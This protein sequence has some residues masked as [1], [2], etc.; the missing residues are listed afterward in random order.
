MSLLFQG[1]GTIAG[2][3]DLG[4]VETFPVFQSAQR[5][6]I[7]QDTCYV[8]LEAQLVRGGLLHPDSPQGLSLEESFS[9][10]LINGRIY[11]SLSEIE[12]ALHLVQQSQF[13]KSHP[14]PVAAAMEV[15]YI[16][17]QVGL[18]ILELQAS[19]GGFW[20]DSNEEILSLERAKGLISAAL[21]DKLCARLDRQELID[22]NTAEKL[23]LSDFYQRCILNQE[24]GLRLLPVNQ[25]SRGT[26]CLRSGIN[27]GIFRAVQEGL[28]D[29]QVTVRLLEAQLFAGGITDPRTGHRLTVDEAVRHGLMDQDLSCALLT[30]QLQSGG[31]IDPVSRERLELDESIQKNLLSPRMALKVLESLWAF[32]GIL[33]PESGELL[34]IT[35]AL[36]QGVISGDLARNILHKRHSIGAIYSPESGQVIPLAHVEEVLG[37]EAAMVLQQTVIPDILPA[38]ASKGSLQCSGS[39]IS[40][41][42]SPAPASLLGAQSD[43]SFLEVS[44][45]QEQD[46]H[47]LLSY[48]MTHSYINAHSGERLVLLEPE[49]ME[50]TNVTGT[51]KAQTRHKPQLIEPSDSE[52]GEAPEFIRPLN[53]TKQENIHILI[54][55]KERST[56]S[57]SRDD[58]QGQDVLSVE[59]GIDITDNISKTAFNTDEQRVAGNASKETSTDGTLVNLLVTGSKVTEPEPEASALFV[60][61]VETLSTDSTIQSL[62]SDMEGTRGRVQLLGMTEL[63]SWRK[64]QVPV[65]DQNILEENQV[66]CSLSVKNLLDIKSENTADKTTSQDTVKESQPDQLNGNA[67]QVLQVWNTDVSDVNKQISAQTDTN[68][69]M[70]N[71]DLLKINPSTMSVDISEERELDHMAT[72]LLQG[73]LLNIGNQRLPLDEAV[74]QD[75][76]PYNTAVKVMSK[77]ELLGGFLNVCACQQLSFDD[78]IQE[79]LLDKDFMTKVIKSEKM[80]AGVFDVEHGRVCSLREA[81]EEGLLDTDTVSYLLEGQIV[82]GG[83]IDLKKG[84]KVSVE[85]A[86]KLGLIEE[87]Q[88]DQ[89]LI[90]EKACH[91]KNSDPHVIQT[92][93]KLQLQMNGIIDPETKQPVPLQQA[94]QK[95]LIGHEEAEQMLLEQIAGGGIVHHG[96]G[97]RISVTNAIHQ[98]LIDSSLAPKLEQF[99]KSRQNQFSSDLN[100]PHA[101]AAVRF[102]YDDASKSNIT[103]ADAV[104]CGLIDQGAANKAMDSLFVKSGVLDPKNACLIPYSELIKQGKIDTGKGWRFLE[105]RP[106]RGIP[107]KENGCLMTVPE[108][109]NAG[110][111]DSIPALRLLQ[112]QADSGGIINIKSGEKLPLLE[113]VEKGFVQKDM[114][115]IIAKNQFLKGG[116]VS[117]ISSQRVPSLKEAVQHGLISKEMA[118]ELCDNLGLV[119]PFAPQGIPYQESSTVKSCDNVEVRGVHFADIQEPHSMTTELHKDMNEQ[120]QVIQQ[121]PSSELEDQKHANVSSMAVGKDPDVSLEVLSQFV[122]KAEKRLQEAIEECIPKQ[123][124]AVEPQQESEPRLSVPVSQISAIESV[125]GKSYDVIPQT[126]KPD[127]K[128]QPGPVV[129]GTETDDITKAPEPL[130]HAKSIHESVEK[131]ED[132]NEMDVYSDERSVEPNLEAEK[133]VGIEF[134]IRRTP[135]VHT[136]SDILD[137]DQKEVKVDLYIGESSVVAPR[138]DAKGSH[139]L[140]TSIVKKSEHYSKTPGVTV[141]PLVYDNENTTLRADIEI[142]RES[143]DTDQESKD[144][145]IKEESRVYLADLKPSLNVTSPIER[146]NIMFKRD[147]VINQRSEDI[148][149]KKGVRLESEVVKASD[150]TDTSLLEESENTFSKKADA[151]DQKDA[152]DLKEF[153]EVKDYLEDLKSP[154][155]MVTSSTERK[156]GKEVVNDQNSEDAVM[157]KKVDLEV[158]KGG[159]MTEVSLEVDIEVEAG[160]EIIKIHQKFDDSSGEDTGGQKYVEQIKTDE[161]H[162]LALKS[163]CKYVTSPAEGAK[164]FEK[165]ATDTNQ[166]DANLGNLDITKTQ[167]KSEGSSS[168]HMEKRFT[169]EFIDND[170]DEK[171]FDTD[172]KIVGQVKAEMLGVPNTG[173]S[174]KSI[175]EGLQ[176]KIEVVKSQHVENTSPGAETSKYDA[177][178]LMDGCKNTKDELQRHIKPTVI[179]DAS[180]TPVEPEMDH[181]EDQASDQDKKRKKKRKNKKTKM[182]ITQKESEDSKVDEPVPRPPTDVPPQRETISAVRKDE[183]EPQPQ[184][185]NQA[186]LEKEALLMKAKE[187]ILRK[188]FERG[189]SEK[190]AAEELEALR[191]GSAKERHVTAEDRVK[192]EEKSSSLDVKKTETDVTHQTKQ[193]DKNKNLLPGNVITES[194]STQSPF[195]QTDLTNDSIY[196]KQNLIYAESSDAAMVPNKQISRPTVFDR[197][198]GK[199]QHQKNEKP[200]DSAVH[201]E[202][203]ATVTGENKDQQKSVTSTTFVTDAV[204][205]LVEKMNKEPLQALT[206]EYSYTASE[207]NDESSIEESSESRLSNLEEVPESD[208]T[209]CWE[210][211]DVEEHQEGVDEKQTED[212]VRKQ[213]SPP[214]ISK[215]S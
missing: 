51:I 5:G 112:C 182:V 142:E 207:F 196:K 168:E 56:F 74:M 154:C 114:A 3:I 4:T 214:Q 132:K 34:L 49:L 78:V 184:K 102:M 150:L 204:G 197:Q 107:N 94:L 54:D 77:A 177:A 111:V 59:G 146:M 185:S 10:G 199:T 73:G 128:M 181:P 115:M 64:G 79:G 87:Q 93:L 140:E 195:S 147:A 131:I 17:E 65:S 83:I 62:S 14:I 21:Y 121:Y 124:K 174:I 145:E 20:V 126:T 153:K 105:V 113:A 201:A 190:Q 104:S 91:G 198:D 120:L 63:A 183:M 203:Y 85:H 136:A 143:V 171:S 98:G 141:A 133:Q 97:V 89:L 129:S 86:A 58:D 210:D 70:E 137:F 75:L 213:K 212:R 144:V 138:E 8:L 109:L 2:V 175:S 32:M 202:P 68:R 186:Q 33:W 23:N 155:T 80:M 192:M 118:A 25:Q 15:G 106:F 84:K 172:T 50:F 205:E 95:G 148:H 99:E 206:M 53:Q 45:P 119:D 117:S 82:S 162:L 178:S 179:N 47:H 41:P 125:F 163:P 167:D 66:E 193:K 52:A 12:A 69:N 157:K 35:D 1:H 29:Q 149:I 108:A 48:L 209:E 123:H 187:S 110:Q 96:S 37:P 26:I 19:T 16:K 134:E 28:I 166:K 130:F 161:I 158:V 90:L 43:I 156:F 194:D 72:E 60:Q 191:Q 67:R 76:L 61:E 13:T 164:K 100:V 127:I 9:S 18:R 173:D 139:R 81:A 170:D 159:D 200:E 116:L 7:D 135:M 160:T 40:S 122:L 103:L 57:I 165:N 24:T 151:L 6:L 189:V 27:V 42:L 208:T 188:V 38:M 36:Q 180:K 169:K 88:K 55:G 44:T 11:R 211:E 152:E 215:V 101:Q 46:L 39:S 71:A 92:K 176:Q 22:P 31:I 30:H